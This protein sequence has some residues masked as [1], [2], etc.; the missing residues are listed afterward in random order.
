LASGGGRPAESSPALSCVNQAAIAA[1]V[2]QGTA[3][4]LEGSL[5]FNG[6]P[7]ELFVFPQSGGTNRTGVVVKL[8]GC[9][10]GVTFPI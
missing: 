5:D 2:P 9:M 4:V 6:E 7:S 10:P 3:P 8:S 1:G